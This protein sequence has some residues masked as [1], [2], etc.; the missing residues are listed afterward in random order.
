MAD[1][2]VSAEK[3]ITRVALVIFSFVTILLVAMRTVISKKYIEAGTG[4]YIG[5]KTLALVFNII[6]VAFVVAILAYTM[7]R[8]RKKRFNVRPDGRALGIVSLIMTAGFIYDVYSTMTI[9]LTSKASHH[10]ISLF[11][12]AHADTTNIMVD[13]LQ[14]Y[15]L[16]IGAILAL[17]SV[18][19]FLIMA[20]DCFG[21]TTRY[22]RRGVLALAPLWWCVFRA[23]YF[24]LI[25]M[26]FSKISDLLYEVIMIGFML[27]F[28]SAFARISSR[29]DG[30]HAV[31]RAIGYGACAAVF[32]AISSIPRIITRLM[33]VEG[34]LYTSPQDAREIVFKSEYC[35]MALAIF[36]FCAVF[37]FYALGRVARGRAYTEGEREEIEL[38]QLSD[39]N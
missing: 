11:T 17:I 26:N 5:G 28:F 23:V 13:I 8:F 32:A 35:F 12:S 6:L 4:F 10:F 2:K 3:R 33:G 30:E 36:I 24:M 9:F 39:E 21:G 25:P 14:G 19:Y 7:V 16:L 18:I 15:A 20:F 34:V 27:L 1:Y 37:V 22:S 29:V 31:G 38:S